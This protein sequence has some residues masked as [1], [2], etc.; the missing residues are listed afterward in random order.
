MASLNEIADKIKEGANKSGKVVGKI[1][2]TS[3]KK[4]G[5][6]FEIS[7]YRLKILDLEAQMD[8]LLKSVGKEVYK[9]HAEPEREFDEAAMTVILES[10]DEKQEMIDELI[11]KIDNITGKVKCPSCGFAPKQDMNFCPSCGAAITPDE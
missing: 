10:I 9:N 5:D 1:A 6:V 2:E 4:A 7:K 11:Q 3:I 8:S